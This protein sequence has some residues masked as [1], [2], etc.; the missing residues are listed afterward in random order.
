MCHLGVDKMGNVEVITS[1]QV[2]TVRIDMVPPETI[3]SLSDTSDTGWYRS[4]PITVTM[5]ISDNLSDVAQ[6]A[7]RVDTGSWVNEPGAGP[8][9]FA[10][11]GQGEHMVTYHSQDG[12]GNWE[13]QQEITFGLDSVPPTIT[14]ELPADGA[15]ITDTLQPIQAVISDTLSGVDVEKTI[16]Y[17]DGITVT[18]EVSLGEYGLRLSYVPDPGSPLEEG[19]HTAFIRAYDQAGNY[20]EALWRFTVDSHTEVWVAGPLDSTITNQDA[21]TLTVMVEAGQP[22]TVIATNS[23]ITQTYVTS[24]GL[25]LIPGWPLD[26]GMNNISIDAEDLAGNTAETTLEVTRDSHVHSALIYSSLTSYTPSPTR[27]G[28]GLDVIQR[29]PFLIEVSP[30]VGWEISDWEVKIISDTQIV[31]S[32]QGITPPSLSWTAYWDGQI[33]SQITQDAPDG[34]YQYQLVYTATQ[35]ETTNT[36]ESAIGTLVVDN[37]APSKPDVNGLPPIAPQSPPEFWFSHSAA[38]TGSATG[39]ARRVV[40]YEDH[41][42][43]SIAEVSPNGNW[44]A[45]IPLVDGQTITLT[46]VAVDAAGNES[47]PTMVFIVGLSSTD[48]F[49]SPHASLSDMYI[50]GGES[51]VI[52]ATTRPGGAPIAWVN[53]EVPTQP[54]R[55]ELSNTQGDTWNGVW[56]TPSEGPYQGVTTVRLHGQD[57]AMPPN[58][59]EQSIFPYLDL[60]PPYLALHYPTDGHVQGTPELFLG[61]IAEPYST[62]MITATMVISPQVI[63]TATATVPELGTWQA[64][65]DILTD[66]IYDVTVQ[67]VDLAGNQGEVESV[68]VLV[69][70]TGPFLA[71]MSL[72]PGRYVN[73]SDPEV[74]DIAFYTEWFDLTGV[75]TSEVDVPDLNWHQAMDPFGDGWISPYENLLN[76]SQGL[77]PFT[78][79]ATDLLGNEGVYTD[80]GFIVDNNSPMVSDPELDT[81]QGENLYLPYDDRLYYGPNSAG[82]LRLSVDIT[83]TFGITE[84]SGLDWVYFPDIM[85]GEATVEYFG[86]EIVTAS[87][88][89]TVGGSETGVYTTTTKDR[90]WNQETCTPFDLVYD[91]QPPEIG[92]ADLALVN[93]VNVNLVDRTLYYGP[94]S[95]GTLIV[96]VPATETY[97]TTQS[98]ISHVTFPGLFGGEEAIDT[99]SPYQREYTIEY[100]ISPNSVYDLE[101]ADRVANVATTPITVTEDAISP[102][103]HV[104]LPVQAGLLFEVAWTGY[105]A[106]AGIEGFDVEYQ[107]DGQ[108]WVPWIS[109]TLDTEAMFV[110]ESGHTYN[111][112][113]TAT[114]RVGNA[115]QDEASVEVYS[116]VKYYSFGGQRV[117][118]R[119]MTGSGDGEVIYLSGDHLGSVSLA[120][121]ADGDLVSQARY[122]PYGQVRWSGETVMP[123]KYAFTGQRQDGFG[124]MDYHARFYSSYLNRWIQPDDIIP[125]PVNPQD[126]DRYG[127]VRNNPIRYIDPTGHWTEEELEEYLGRD[128]MEKYFGEDG[129]L[130]GRDA[131]LNFLQSKN[132]TNID[133]LKIISSIIEPLSFA[134]DKG[135][136]ISNIDAIGARISVTGGVVGYGGGNFDVLINF[137]SG[138]FGAFLSPEMGILIGEGLNIVGGILLIKNCPTNEDY[139][140][141]SKSLGIVGG[142]IVGLNAEGMVG[143]I[144]RNLSPSDVF[145]GSFI[146]AGPAVP[147]I[148][149]YGT[150]SYAVEILRVNEAGNEWFPRLP[151]FWDAIMD[152]GEVL[153]NDILNLP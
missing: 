40:F 138:E 41:T 135:L 48:V 82:Y 33:G 74:E 17:V 59:G 22:V 132:T 46:A 128:W 37:Q 112:R 38:M 52:T 130:H 133:I 68:Q 151:S 31:A 126:L 124:L 44:L 63:Y 56:N 152:I 146:G 119:T 86:E 113:V 1:T 26:E 103:V 24:D 45:E 134:H 23:V 116:V 136:D 21:I 34:N 9:D 114:D 70:T 18:S 87:Y 111:F 55:V 149:I 145:D 81:D 99:V 90:A 35:S 14:I 54:E 142:D 117:A 13:T 16:M 28:I 62:I 123:T 5:A 106:G 76:A 57:E 102:T 75:Y 25:Q 150:I 110:G 97:T 120:T 53:A 143:G 108:N 19:T 140:G 144:H 30:L 107:V 43:R 104:L 125:D 131:F 51:V 121:D 42:P 77:K 91:N 66:G 73:G 15:L 88:T 89:Y 141:T 36:V 47:D 92:E 153:T 2:V 105:D 96:T 50:G 7:Y 60:I 101:A 83:D 32:I 12:A 69:D 78:L 127:Y 65:V 6:S 39:N 72:L 64:E 118:M 100:V 67:A 11:S 98:G 148:G 8:V 115:G 84:V 71:E 95:S 61:G 147:E 137:T 79:E 20:T 3:A 10:V 109:D 27:Y 139:R 85:S 80:T 29:A 122:T 94:L 49:T 58:L 129:L 4:D 93:G